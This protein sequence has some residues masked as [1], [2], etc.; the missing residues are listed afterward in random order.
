[1]KKRE[2]GRVGVVLA[3]AAAL[4]GV[5]LVA[6]T[7]P[8]QAHVCAYVVVYPVNVS[9]TVND[10]PPCRTEDTT[11]HVCVGVPLKDGST[12]YVDERVCAPL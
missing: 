6:T 11:D 9:V 12:T 8:S 4:C 5:G 10:S 2:L 7:P 3:A 1:M